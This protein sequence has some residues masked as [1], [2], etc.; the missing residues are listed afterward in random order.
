MADNAA[1]E[2]TEDVAVTGVHP[3]STPALLRPI[4]PKRTRRCWQNP[5][6]LNPLQ[7]QAKFV[8]YALNRL[9]FTRSPT[10]VIELAMS[11]PSDLELCTRK[12]TALFA[13]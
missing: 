5:K 6:L 7:T 9:S 11:V 10:V 4:L 1:E 12:Q 2:A 8:G 13:R 3:R